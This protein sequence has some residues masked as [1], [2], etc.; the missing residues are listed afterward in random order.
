MIA[1]EGHLVAFEPGLPALRATYRT[2]SADL[3]TLN[4]TRQII[5]QASDC[6]QHRVTRA[7]HDFGFVAPA[8]RFDPCVAPHPVSK[9]HGLRSCV[10]SPGRFLANGG[11]GPRY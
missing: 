3:E 10:Q 8:A 9:N 4:M 11:S 2:G 5:D 6:P 7:K 1:R